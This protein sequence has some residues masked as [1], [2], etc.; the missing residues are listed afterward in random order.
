MT[1]IREERRLYNNGMSSL[2]FKLN[3]VTCNTSVL[4]QTKKTD[5]LIHRLSFYVILYRIYNLLKTSL[6]FWVTLYMKRKL[7]AQK[8]HL[9]TVIYV[10]AITAPMHASLRLQKYFKYTYFGGL[11]GSPSNFSVCFCRFGNFLSHNTNIVK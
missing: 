1:R 5:N 2:K 9:L 10:T 3:F 6:V 7:S 8:L 4:L 11:T